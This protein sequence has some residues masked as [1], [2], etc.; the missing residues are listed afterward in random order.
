VLFTSLPFLGF[1]VLVVPGYALLPSRTRTGWLLLASY[2]FYA[3]AYPPHLL[4]L[5]GVTA[6]AHLIGHRVTRR[7]W[8]LPTGIALI[9]LPLLIFKYGGFLTGGST[10]LGTLLL[11]TGISFFTFQAISYLVDVHRGTILAERRPARLA[12]YLAFFPQLLAG[13]IERA[14]MLFPQLTRLGPIRGSNLYLGLKKLL[15]GFFCKL[16]IADHLALIVDA[17]LAEPARASASSLLIAMALFSFQIYYD[18]L[19]YTLIALGL[20]QT[21]GIQLSPNFAKPYLAT[22]LRDFWHRWHITLSTWFRDYVYIP[23]GGKTNTGTRSALGVITTFTLSGLW[24]GAAITFLLWGSVHGLLYLLERLL[25]KTRL[26]TVDARAPRI[27]LVFLVVTLAWTCFRIPTLHDLAI[28]WQKLL[29][30]DTTIPIGHLHDVFTRPETTTYLLLTL[31]AFTL[32]SSGW[33]DRRIDR[34]PRSRGA[35]AAELVAVDAMLVLVL[36]TGD[37]SARQFLYFRF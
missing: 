4:L 6:T 7:P 8:L 23:L 19:G 14:R 22:S 20:A 34:A 5:L 28:V 37:A 35:L 15:W 18:F 11:P 1:F 13:P 16:V 29:L 33:M 9:L 27:V 25:A 24:H 36:I 2:V 26:A 30:L 31:A 17:I 12:L 10:G 3:W 32:D 21:L